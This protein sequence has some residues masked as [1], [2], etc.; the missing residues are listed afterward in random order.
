MQQNIHLLLTVASLLY[1]ATVARLF[2]VEN[3]HGNDDAFLSENIHTED[4]MNE[5]A[6][7]FLAE[8]DVSMRIIMAGNSYTYQQ[9]MNLKLQQMLDVDYGSTEVV[10]Q[11]FRSGGK[12]IYEH[13]N[14]YDNGA[15]D[16]LLAKDNNKFF[17]LQ[18]QSQLPS[19]QQ[20]QPY[21]GMSRDAVAYFREELDLDIDLILMM[22]WGREKQDQNIGFNMCF[23]Q[24]Q[25]NLKNGYE[26][27]RDHAIAQNPNKPNVYIAP[28]GLAFQAIHDKYCDGGVSTPQCTGQNSGVSLGCEAATDGNTD[29]TKL[30]KNDG[31]HPTLHGTYL[32]ACVLYATMT[33]KSPVG[34]PGE[35]LQ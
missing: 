19:L 35:I 8:D 23:T 4:E 33:G 30:Y 20:L 29:F 21:Y 9:D 12:K 14:R 13:A 24:M 6:D 17:V 28:V 18:D 32:A 16:A 15:Y 7:R 5:N 27:Y 22:T 34:M 25:E 31:S 26:D 3:N 11:P 10:R 1:F 2:S